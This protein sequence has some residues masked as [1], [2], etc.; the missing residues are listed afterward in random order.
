[1]KLYE[2]NTIGKEIDPKKLKY[3]DWCYYNAS[4]SLDYYIVDAQDDNTIEMN[5]KRN[6]QW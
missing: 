5:K 2:I 3:L 4:E 1:M 6:T